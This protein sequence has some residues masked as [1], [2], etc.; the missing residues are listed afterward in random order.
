MGIRML[1]WKSVVGEVNITGDFKLLGLRIQLPLSGLLVLTS[2]TYPS[3]QLRV[4]YIDVG[5]WNAKFSM[6]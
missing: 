5:D 4:R 1:F 6:W 3:S 2:V